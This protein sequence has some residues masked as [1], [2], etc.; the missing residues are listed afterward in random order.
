MHRQAAQRKS[1]QYER[2]M[3]DLIRLDQGALA[4]LEIREA[5]EY[6]EK[7]LHRQLQKAGNVLNVQKVLCLAFESDASGARTFLS[8]MLTAFDCDA[9][10]ADSEILYL[11]QDAWNYFPHRDLQGRC[12]AELM[13]DLFEDRLGES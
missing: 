13:T 2:T 8:A 3:R 12:P 9:A 7:L 6:T 11:I 10:S 4:L 1:S 5:R